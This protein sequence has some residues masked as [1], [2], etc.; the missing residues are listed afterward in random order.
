MAS[1][2]IRGGGPL[3]LGQFA[4]FVLVGISNTMLSYVVYAAL[5]LAAV[6]YAL[7]GALG[8]AAGAVNGYRLNRRW[9]FHRRDSTGLLA[10]YL[11]VQLA[12]LGATSGLLWL[13]V[14]GG[15]LHRLPSYALTIPFVTVATFVANRSWV[16]ATS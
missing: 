14:A 13:L 11:V 8:F 16:F 9:T 10:R 4:R 3:P 5:V 7:A 2:A 1:N 12:G 6:P 15:H